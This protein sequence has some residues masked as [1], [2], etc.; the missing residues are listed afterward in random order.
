MRKTA[1]LPCIP[2]RGPKVPDHDDWFHEVKQDGYRLVVRRD[3]KR[4]QLLTRNGHD[5]TGRYP[6]ITEA[7]LRIRASSFVI[8]GEAVLLGVDGI[9]DF[10]GLHSRQA[11]HEV[12]LY[13]F[14]I[15]VDDGSDV[16]GLPLHMRKTNLERLLRRRVDGIHMAPFEQGPI[17]PDLFRAACDMRLEGLVSKRRDSRYRPGPSRDWVKSKNPQHPSIQR[18]K[19]AFS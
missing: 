13:A 5:W 2:T 11:D 12:Q 1:F 3:G 4:V 19:D 8:D 17:G 14:D 6:L 10:D 18:A 7:A 15:M 9:S 16:R